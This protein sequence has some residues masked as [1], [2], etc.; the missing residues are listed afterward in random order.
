M[1]F[2]LKL[3]LKLK[4]PYKSMFGSPHL[5][6]PSNTARTFQNVKQNYVEK[7]MSKQIF[8]YF[9]RIPTIAK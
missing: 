7:N 8:A 9:R 1:F 6:I 2:E 5:S 3:F 4:N